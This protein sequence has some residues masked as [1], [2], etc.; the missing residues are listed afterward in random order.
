MD[1][2]I[3]YMCMYS[4]N[5]ATLLSP[6]FCMFTQREILFGLGEGLQQGKQA[7]IAITASTH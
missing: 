2:N 5:G 7:E 6:P 4:F 3:Y 1:W